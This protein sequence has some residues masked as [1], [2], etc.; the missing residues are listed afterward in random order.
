VPATCKC[1]SQLAADLPPDRHGDQLASH[2]RWGEC[3]RRLGG[4]HRV[5]A[6][7]GRRMETRRKWRVSAQ[8]ARVRRADGK[9]IVTD[10]PFTETKELI[11]G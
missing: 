6:G 10:G 1:A 3:V 7:I 9:V 4:I 2:P 8:G 5:F 11:A